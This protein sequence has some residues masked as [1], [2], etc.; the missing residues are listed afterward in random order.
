MEH[1]KPNVNL[2]LFVSRS[3]KFLRSTRDV[4]LIVLAIDFLRQQLRDPVHSTATLV[5]AVEQWH[6]WLVVIVYALTILVWLW[7]AWKNRLR[8]WLLIRRL[9]TGYKKLSS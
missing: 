9:Q 5:I 6:L 7:V 8:V 4:M 3:M 1:K 2:E